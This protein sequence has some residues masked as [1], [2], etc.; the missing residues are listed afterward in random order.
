MAD[1]KMTFEESILRLDEIVKIL[2]GG[3]A[4]LEES[5]TLFEEGTRLIK[6]CGKILDSAEQKVVRLSKGADGEPVE[7]LFDMAEV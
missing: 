7:N 6:N 3:T 4:P 1:K 5:L 2:E